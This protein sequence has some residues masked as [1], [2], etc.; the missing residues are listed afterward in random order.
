MDR[1]GSNLT[2]VRL[3]IAICEKQC[4]ESQASRPDSNRKV[5]STFRILYRRSSLNPNE[6]VRQD[7]LIWSSR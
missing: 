5:D 2:F 6:G 7:K 3:A 4:S 1:E